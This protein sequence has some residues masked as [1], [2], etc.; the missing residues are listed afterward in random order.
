MEEGESGVRFS[1]RNPGKGADHAEVIPKSENG[2]LSAV[3]IISL[4]KYSLG[5]GEGRVAAKIFV[6]VN[7]RIFLLRV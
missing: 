2:I 4:C 1:S 7:S 6:F 5:W 3:K